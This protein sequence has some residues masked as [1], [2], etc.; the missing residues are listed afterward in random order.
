MLSQVKAANPAAY[1]QVKALVATATG[2][3]PGKLGDGTILQWLIANGPAIMAFIMQIIAMFGKQPTPP[4]P[5]N[6]VV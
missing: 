6:P 2:E 4:T 1:E 3:D 5:P